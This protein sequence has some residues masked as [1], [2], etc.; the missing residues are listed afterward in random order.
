MRD[1]AKERLKVIQ[2]ILN[3]N[4]ISINDIIAVD[5]ERIK[6]G[7]RDRGRVVFE[8]PPEGIK[9][10]SLELLLQ[11]IPWIKERKCL[12][13][14]VYDKKEAQMAAYER[15]F[16]NLGI[17]VDEYTSIEEQIKRLNAILPRLNDDKI[18]ML[19]LRYGIYDGLPR[20]LDEIA[21]AFGV[22]RERVRMKLSKI[23]RTLR[24]EFMTVEDVGEE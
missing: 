9:K 5:L 10:R 2:N 18:K 6:I 22:T 12:D 13:S 1:Y 4:G 23:L 16:A 24:K 21:N 11:H 14:L 8:I 19:N 7:V 15:L 20:A 3:K 17:N